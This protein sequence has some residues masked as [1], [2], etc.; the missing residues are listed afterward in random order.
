[1]KREKG[2][3]AFA[4]LCA[5]LLLLP[6]A[7]AGR[8]F[9]CDACGASGEPKARRLNDETINGE[10]GYWVEYVCA[11]C[12][13]RLPGMAKAWV[14]TGSA[15]PKP[16]DPTAKPAAAPQT[17][18]P[19]VR[20]TK[21]PKATAGPKKAPAAQTKAPAARKQ[22]SGG[23]SAGRDRRDLEKYPRFSAVYPYRRLNL[24]GDPEAFAPLCGEQ[25]WPEAESASPLLR[26]LGE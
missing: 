22:Q 24:E 4:L 21:A 12:G 18:P 13:A 26:M 9:D 17:A 10:T 6:A 15:K 23:T 16:A 1:M 5:V 25:A 8:T 3:R 2:I 14:R 20:E 11:K 7:C 19:A